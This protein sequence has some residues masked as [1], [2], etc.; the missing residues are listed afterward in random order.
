M[1]N[2]AWMTLGDV[3]HWLGRSVFR[4]A[5]SAIGPHARR[6]PTVTLAVATAIFSAGM[7]S[8]RLA[9]FAYGRAFKN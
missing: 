1:T 7:A 2:I 3:A 5:H 9:A 6:W 8:F 4:P